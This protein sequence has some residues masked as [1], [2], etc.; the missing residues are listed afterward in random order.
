MMEQEREIFKSKD[1]F[2]QLLNTVKE[3]AEKEIEIDR[4]ENDLWQGLLNL[5]RLMLQEYVNQQGN[6]DEGPSISVGGKTY[7]RLDRL[8]EKRYVSVFGEII[9]LQ[10]VYGTRE[11]QKHEIVPLDARLDL[12][13]SDFSFL[14][15][16]WTQDYYIMNI[17]LWEKV[18]FQKIMVNIIY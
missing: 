3:V 4:V 17:L 18:L 14:L 1:Q 16:E 13:E 7:R 6:G 9:I 5:G 11:N 12:P 8:H 2:D 10:T 15:Q